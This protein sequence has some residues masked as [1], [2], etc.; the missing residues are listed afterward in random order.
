VANDRSTVAAPCVPW[1]F[2]SNVPAFKEKEDYLKWRNDP[3]TEH[4]LFTGAI[5]VNPAM[6]CNA[7]TNPIR[8]LTAIIGDY[9]SN[10]STAMDASVLA[11]APAGL[12]PNWL[13]RTFS[14]GRRVVWL[15]SEPVAFDAVLSRRF[16]DIAVR[17]LRATSLLPGL[18]PS[19]WHNPLKIYDVGVAWEKLSD[20][21]LST[22]LIHLWLTEASKQ[23]NWSKL[24]ELRIPLE[25]VAAEIERQY[26]GQWNGTFQVGARGSVFWE[27]KS[28]PTA[29]IVTEHGMIAFSSHKLFHSW[30]EVL[31]AAFVRKYAQD[32]IGGAIEGVYFD[33]RSYYRKIDNLWQSV[34]K[35]DFVKYLCAVKGLDSGKGKGESASETT[36]AEV[37]VQLHRRVAGVVPRV[38]D[39]RDVIDINGQRFLNI[40]YVRPL[41][42][43]DESQEWG[44]NFPW[45]A[46]FLETRFDDHERVVM[47]A[48]WKRFYGSALAG[49]L[50]PGHALFLVGDVNIGKTL[51]SN[52]MIGASVG[53]FADASSHIS[54]DSEFNRELVGCALWTIDDGQVA[55]DPVSH[56]KFSEA[57]KR[58]V[59]TPTVVYRAMRQD[60]QSTV[61]NGRLLITLNYDAYSMQMIPDLETSMEEKVIVERF[62]SGPFPDPPAACAHATR[63]YEA[64]IASELPCLLRWL[65]DWSPPAAIMGDERLGVAS[66]INSDMRS[67]ALYSGDVGD[68]LE[69]VALFVKSLPPEQGDWVGNASAFYS[70]ASIYETTKP[71]IMKYS[72]RIIGRRFSEASRIRDSGISV[73]DEDR[74]KGNR[75]RI[76]LGEREGK[77]V[78]ITPAVEEPV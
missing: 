71:L 10:I 36:R 28:N 33:G 32:K 59:A 61:H 12:Q 42:P 4:L 31:G 19:C 11:N 57:V 29:A 7:K 20:E 22:S 73:V 15:L 55:A 48:W 65:L 54:K 6:R 52:K 5:G 63:P 40:A 51:F 43:S 56:R 70:Q 67:K 46:R 53:G 2:K 25:D 66:Y 44:A 26:P 23:T 62:R 13:S 72:P 14:G 60:G 77:V 58:V 9:D 27:N 24:G 47:L 74:R 21:P 39:P 34:A 45:C 1:E 35:E 30:A 18:D 50:L 78:R 76:A 8:Q 3:S 38:F 37:F 49:D 75:Y 16:F 17:E 69:I 41:E 68:L 64:A